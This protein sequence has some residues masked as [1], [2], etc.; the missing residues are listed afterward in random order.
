MLKTKYKFKVITIEHDAYAN[1]DIFRNN[2]RNMLIKAG[3]K[4]LFG[5]IYPNYPEKWIV[6]KAYFE[7]WWINPDYINIS[8]EYEKLSAS[9]AMILLRNNLV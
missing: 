2:Q 8:M 5:D 3:Y 1:G 9:Q 6:D 4:M 7:D